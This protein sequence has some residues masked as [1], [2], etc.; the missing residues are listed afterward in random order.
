MSKEINAVFSYQIIFKSVKLKK[1]VKFLKKEI[2]QKR[3]KI[4]NSQKQTVNL[5]GKFQ[6]FK[7]SIS[8]RNQVELLSYHHKLLQCLTFKVQKT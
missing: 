1:I 6:I 4:L 7:N 2:I 5:F 8:N 3:G